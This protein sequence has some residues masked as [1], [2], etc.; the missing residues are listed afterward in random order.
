MIL[1]PTI[2]LLISI[3][4][5]SNSL[6][7]EEKT[8]ESGLIFKELSNARVSYD[9]F[10]IVYH[11]DLRD[12]FNVKTHV[13]KAMALMNEIYSTGPVIFGDIERAALQRQL[14]Y[15][16][17]QETDINLYSIKSLKRDKRALE[18]IGA[19]EHWAFGLV[20]AETAR[21]YEAKIKDLE[22][23][24]S[25]LFKMDASGMIFFKE[26]IATNKKVFEFLTN[27][28][29]SIT[30]HINTHF[31]EAN[32]KGKEMIMQS[33]INI[34]NL[35]VREHEH[36]SIQ[37]LKHLEGAVY[38]KASQLIPPSQFKEDLIKIERMLPENQRLP[39]DI[40]RE[41]PLNI[42][43]YSTT[44]ATLINK[45]LLIEITIPKIDRELYIAYKI[46]PIPITVDGY[47][48]IIIPNMSYVLFDQNTAGFIPITE[49]EFEMSK[50]NN[51]L[52]KI[53]NPKENVYHDYK[54]NC[55]MSLLLHPSQ[56]SFKRLCNVKTI[57]I[58]N[59]VLPFYSNNQYYLSIAK[60][61]SII[62][63]CK[64][65]S[66]NSTYIEKSGLLRLKDDCKVRTDKITLRPRTQTR[67]I[68]ENDIQ[69]L[70]S[71]RNISFD[72]VLDQ[73]KNITS[74]ELLNVIEPSVLI[75]NHIEDFNKLS[76]KADD[77]LDRIIVDQKFDDMH[78]KH[79][80]K[81]GIILGSSILIPLI[82]V[83]IAV[84][85]L[86][87]KFN[88]PITLR[89]ILDRGNNIEQ[90]LRQV[91]YAKVYPRTPRGSRNNM[92]DDYENV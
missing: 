64:G 70:T 39:I 20:D 49:Q 90:P 48:L 34:I 54:D 84:I 17:Q 60:P 16:L 51:K 82:L 43:H 86:H 56:D 53:I 67:I 11:A 58:T 75:Q 19:F 42:F 69:I 27:Q 66:I 2:T 63:F 8:F 50:I 74:P 78:N 68:I 13:E 71:L 14:E 30:D 25:K 62:E 76:S 21:E 52:E 7:F 57:P 1:T 4:V 6:E 31:K 46:V 80:I 72:H 23:D 55:E 47:L 91:S 45:R 41:N 83:T 87:L 26:N 81:H 12:Y 22:I 59:Y 33:L 37:I 40:Y 36:A 18:F 28:T 29:R 24:T 79:D 61:T 35:W 32:Q 85:F 65:K 5:F 88:N 3:F 9:G 38:G 92:N 73:V 15:M 10:V 44:K 77:L 89:N